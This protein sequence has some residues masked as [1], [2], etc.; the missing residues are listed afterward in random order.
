MSLYV[1]QNS[2][3]YNTAG[4]SLGKLRG[5]VICQYRFTAAKKCTVLTSDV[6]NGGVYACV[7]AKGIWEIS[8]PASQ[9]YYKPKSYLKD[10]DFL[11]AL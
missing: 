11:K 5:V 6:D 2:L 3:I 9:F 1:C 10:K 8:V 7:E 4:K